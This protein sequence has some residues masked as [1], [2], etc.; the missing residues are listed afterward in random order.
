[1]ERK[2]ELKEIEQA[3]IGYSNCKFPERDNCAYCDE[4]CPDCRVAVCSCL[5]EG[6][7][8]GAKCRQ[9]EINKL[10]SMLKICRESLAQY[11]KLDLKHLENLLKN[12]GNE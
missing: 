1:M 9:P 2:L 8:A 10:V 5:R 7:V 6:F 11:T 4:E 3:A 12:Y